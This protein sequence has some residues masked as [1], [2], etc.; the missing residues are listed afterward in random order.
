MTAIFLRGV[1]SATLAEIDAR[2]GQESELR[3]VQMESIQWL[4]DLAA[5]ADVR[6][7]ILNGNFVTDIN[8]AE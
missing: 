4:V 8:G 7:I 1:Y 5:R 6:R 2:F 3:R